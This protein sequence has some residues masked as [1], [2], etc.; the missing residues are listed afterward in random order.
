MCKLHL[1]SDTGIPAQPNGR[2]CVTLLRVPALLHRVD[3]GG[4]GGDG[5]KQYHGM[6]NFGNLLT[7]TYLNHCTAGNGTTIVAPR[8]HRV[9][10]TRAEGPIRERGHVQR[11]AGLDPPSAKQRTISGCACTGT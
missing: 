4:T 3:Y 6:T 10:G 1:S 5:P 9:P 7:I 2:P 8:C 11:A